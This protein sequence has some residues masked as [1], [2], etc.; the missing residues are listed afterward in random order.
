VKLRAAYGES[1][2]APGAFDAVRTWSQPGLAGRP[3]FVPQNVG[4]PDLGP[5]ITKEIELGFDASWLN[6]RVRATFTRYNQ[7][8]TEALFQV[9][10]I[11][12]EGFGGSQLLNIGE[13][14]NS[15]ME[16][17]LTTTPI[18]RESWGWD[19][20]ASL[21]TNH[22][23][24]TDLGKA[25][26]FTAL[27][28][29]I[30]KDQ[31]VPV[32]RGKFV[33]N[34]DA[35]AAPIIV[36]NHIYGPQ[37]PTHTINA[38]STV[39]L[40]YGLSVSARGEYRGGN[41]MSVNPMSVERSVRSPLCYPYYVH[42][43]GIV[44]AGPPLVTN[45]DLKPETPAI[46]RAR[47]TPTLYDGAL[48]NWDADY[49]KLRSVSANIPIGFAFPD[50]I[51]TAMLTLAL[52]NSLLWMKEIPWGDPELLGNEGANSA[53]LGQTERVPSPINFRASLRITF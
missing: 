48:Y 4:N 41:V 53:G 44:S 3:A 42:D 33:T 25:R 26:E 34:P 27:N 10:Q 6:D 18:Q 38:S 45:I 37:L 8:T 13:L 43:Q 23:K 22:S 24:A 32:V 19:V 39:R 52:T 30:I 7:R 31:P 21:A 5:E 35:I 17:E 16:I 12:S 15:G 46:W 1:G 20:G 28:G 9:A 29:W 36:D 40:P 49:F 14:R 2:R 11:Q 51:S 50:R 47:C